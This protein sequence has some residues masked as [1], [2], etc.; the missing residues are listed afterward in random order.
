[1]FAIGFLAI[2]ALF[3]FALFR[4]VEGALIFLGFADATLFVGP[5]N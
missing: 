4:L 5:V 3:S 1:M 2:F